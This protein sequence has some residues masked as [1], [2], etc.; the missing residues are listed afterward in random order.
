MKSHSLNGIPPLQLMGIA[1]VIPDKLSH[2]L[3]GIPPLQL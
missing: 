2:S 3:N 1:R